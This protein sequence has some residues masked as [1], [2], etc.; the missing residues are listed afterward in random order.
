MEQY[1]VRTDLNKLSLQGIGIDYKIEGL[2]GELVRT[3]NTGWY[4]VKIKHYLCGRPFV[5]EFTMPK[6]FLK[7]IK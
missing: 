6:T 1:Q 4:V 2:I 7:K 3:Y 5:N